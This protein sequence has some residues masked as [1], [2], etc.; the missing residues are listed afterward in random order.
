MRV[1]RLGLPLRWGCQRSGPRSPAKDRVRLDC[2]LSVATVSS[3]RLSPD[4]KANFASGSVIV[5]PCQLYPGLQELDCAASASGGSD[6]RGL[7]L[8]SLSA[9]YC[10]LMFR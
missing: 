4:I 3:C 7:G 1:I 9:T 2:S 10:H 6:V 5:S 8:S